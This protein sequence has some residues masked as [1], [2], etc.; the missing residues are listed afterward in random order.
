MFHKDLPQSRSDM[1]QID[2]EVD[3]AAD[4]NSLRVACPCTQECVRVK[5]KGCEVILTV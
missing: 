3:L 5:W 1:M 4:I 2:D